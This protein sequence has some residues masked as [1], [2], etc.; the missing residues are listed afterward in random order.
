MEDTAIALLRVAMGVVFIAHGWPKVFG[1]ATANHGSGRTEQLLRSKGIPYP[2]LVA[3]TMGYTELIAGLLVCVGLFTRVAVV[4]L[5]LIVVGAIPMV[6]WKK[7]FVDGWDWPFVLIIVGLVL[8]ASGAGGLS[9][10]SLLG[11]P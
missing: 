1:S 5:I 7:G 4:P 3:K 2:A 10:D 9:V 6:K 11:I 8:M